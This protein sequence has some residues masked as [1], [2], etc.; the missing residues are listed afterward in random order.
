M[1][2]WSNRIMSSLTN[3]IWE[4]SKHCRQGSGRYPTIFLPDIS[5]IVE[6]DLAGGFHIGKLSNLGSDIYLANIQP[7]LQI[8]FVVTYL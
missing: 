7:I 1:P 5:D 4:T 2:T 3:L 8:M 6:I